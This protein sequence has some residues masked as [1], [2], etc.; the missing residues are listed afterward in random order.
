MH[1]PE[2]IAI[3]IFAELSR[4][5]FTVD[6]IAYMEFLICFGLDWHLN[7]PT[8]MEFV[9]NFMKLVPHLGK[10][11]LEEISDLA[12]LQT[13][14]ALS[15][16]SLITVPAS[17]IA[18]CAI[19]VALESLNENNSIGDKTVQD[20][21]R[22]IAHAIPHF[23]TT[24][25]QVVHT[26]AKLCQGIAQS[27]LHLDAEVAID[28]TDDEKENVNETKLEEAE[29][30][31]YYVYVKGYS[32]DCRLEGGSLHVHHKDP[33]GCNENVPWPHSL[34]QSTASF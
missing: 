2:A 26:Q 34:H 25:E 27:F 24:S 7:P 15:K 31:Y 16:Y 9:R 14:M 4:G 20:V 29:R 10:E 1:A 13:E 23:D 32:N 21:L 33:S 28:D 19:D 17:I 12:R 18:Y 6:Q 8:A 5:K 30:G 3:E 22:T 11:I